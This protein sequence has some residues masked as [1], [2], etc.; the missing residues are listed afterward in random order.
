MERT[1]EELRLAALALRKATIDAGNDPQHAVLPVTPC[2]KLLIVNQ[3]IDR[4][5]AFKGTRDRI[6]GVRA[7]VG[8][9]E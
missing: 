3:P 7:E 6:C 5:L 8:S 1:F 9:M 2:E 4:T